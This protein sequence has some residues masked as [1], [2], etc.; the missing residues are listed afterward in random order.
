AVSG[1]LSNG[2][3]EVGG[4]GINESVGRRHTRGVASRGPRGKTLA[5]KAARVRADFACAITDALVVVA[6][7]VIAL[8]IRMLDPGVSP[9]Y[10]P[11]LMTYLPLLAV[12]HIG[13][14]VLTG[15][16]G[17]VWEHASIAEA[18]DRKSVV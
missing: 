6:A 9:R 1:T 5:I 14:N 16:Y 10:W 18:R 15:A 4:I 11:E 8:A 2:A 17:H 13:A 3:R 7:Y 12:L